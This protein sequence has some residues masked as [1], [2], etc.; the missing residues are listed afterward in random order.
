MNRLRVRP[1]AGPTAALAVLSVLGAHL[2]SPGAAPPG[3]AA[4]G[5]APLAGLF[6]N[7]AVTADGAPATGDLDGRGGSL[8]EADLTAAGWS[9][10]ARITVNGTTYTRAEVPPGWPDNVLAAGQSVAIGGRGTALGFLAT[11]TGG[12]ATGSG[13]VHYSDGSSSSYELTVGDW[14]AGSAAVAALTLPHRHTPSG[15]VPAEARLYAVAVPI[16]RG[17]TV[18][19]VTLPRLRGDRY[20]RA[21][22]LHVFDLA[23]R[24]TADAP[25]GRVW[26]AAWTA[27]TGSASAVPESD[28]WTDR[29]LRMVVHPN[30]A[31]RTV[32]IRLT[33]ALSPVPVTFGRVTLAVQADHGAARAA[34]VPL[35]F[36]GRGRTTVPAGG[37][38]YSDPIDLP[39]AEGDELLV[40]IHLP[41]RVLVAARH[42]W[43]LSTSYTTASGAGDHSTDTGGA[44]FTGQM[45]YWAFLAGVDLAT[46]NGRGT[47][48]A[49]G[50]SQTDG[51]HTRPDADHRWPDL[52]AADLHRTAPGT[53]IANAGLSA[54]SLLTDS[55]GSAGAAALNRLDRDVFAQPDARTL[56]L[57]E[58]INDI[59]LHDASAQA[60]TAGIREIAALA[61]AHG[62]RVVV[63]T[64]PPFGGSARWT[65]EREEVR[66]RVNSYIR[67][68]RDF[69]AHT[70]FDLATRD[71]AAPE[72]LRDG[73]HDPHDHLHFDDAGTRL[74]AD[75]L[76]PTLAEVLARGGPAGR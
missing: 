46:A 73:V 71:P 72:R 5:A 9:R 10:G 17:R 59:T 11:A 1:A 22:T 76:A 27:S 15:T 55:T 2:L 16:D 29:T 8:A 34:P 40:S 56:V 44:A 64:I 23:V 65:Q 32:R 48:V 50:D 20:D 52:C 74:L 61:H 6:D 28:G 35:T 4:E 7:T 37:D 57:Y 39:V 70:D 41:G 75:T 68:S 21:P 69:D 53:G 47:V 24:N 19:A 49:L 36:A 67:S 3:A 31:G 12:P 66:Q 13:T 63:A 60:L 14:A 45:S 33:N 51:A 58:G 25:G 18:S 62:M 54:N 30:L 26:E 43:A 42:P 38:A